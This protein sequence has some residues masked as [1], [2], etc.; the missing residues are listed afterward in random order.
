[1]S[2]KMLI[3]NVRIIDPSSNFDAV[4]NLLVCDGKIAA[5]GSGFNADSS[6]EVINGTGLVAA[7][8]F[9]DMHVHLR[10]P[11]QTHKENIESGCLA[12]AAGGV[13]SLV[14]M[15]NTNPVADCPEVINYIKEETAKACGVKV[16]P[17]ASI[18]KGLAGEEQTK[19]SLL[20]QAGAIAVTD[21]G[22]PVEDDAILRRAMVSADKHN[23]TI[24]CHCENMELSRGG[25][26]NKGKISEQLEVPGIPN[27]AEDSDTKRVIDLAEKSGTA[28]HICHVSTRGSVALI[29]EA[30]KRGVRVTAETAPH[31]FTFTETRLLER[32]ADYRMN[33]P[34]RTFADRFAVIEGLCD[35]TIDAIATDHAP[36]TPE[37]KAD[38]LSAPCG[39]IGMETSFSASFKYLKEFMTLSEII[40]C[41]TIK[42][43]QIL[44]LNA[45]TLQIGAPADIV[46]FNP[47]DIWTV[48]PEKLH[49]KSKNAVF[50]GK[51]LLGRIYYTICDGKIVYKR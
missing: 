41:M 17:A 9:I 44:G 27:E 13:T 7:P 28:V 15:P 21:D 48:D 4:T 1:M 5:I 30:K 37:E 43:A 49:G 40:A 14:C 29:R 50:K 19:F 25:V 8:G 39:V 16:Y 45:G 32:D 12:A 35:G 51:N 46:L 23:L 20:R 11:G 24:L 36:H 6:T 47:R 38:F 10:D 3:S 18:T 31:Y 33:P 34:L 26:M 2:D 22:R 42:P